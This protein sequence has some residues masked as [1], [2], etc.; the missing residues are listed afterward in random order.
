VW[1]QVFA[2]ALGRT[3]EQVADPVDA[4]A[5]G[6]AMLAAVALGEMDFDEVPERVRAARS[7]TPE[8]AA[9]AVYDELFGEFVGLYRRNRRAHA[10]LNGQRSAQ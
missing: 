8:S 1:C 6:A 9:S 2:D 10:R 4:N 5:R 3:I 7:Y